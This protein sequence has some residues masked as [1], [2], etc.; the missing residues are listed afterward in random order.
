MT[1]KAWLD[2]DRYD[3]QHLVA[4]LPAGA[5]RVVQEGD[6]FFLTSTELDAC[7]GGADIEEIASRALGH[8]NGIGRLMDPRFRPVS[9]SRRYDDG[10]NAVVFVDAAVA[11]GFRVT[12]EV[13]VVDADGVAK[14]PPA[15]IAPRYLELASDPDVSDVLRI[16]GRS[17]ELS[18]ADMYKVHEIIQTRV[19]RLSD[20]N[21]GISANKEQSFTASADDPAISGEKARH[22]R[23]KGGTLKQSR[24]MSE[25]DARSFIVQVVECWLRDLVAGPQPVDRLETLGS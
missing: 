10:R 14:A 7:S 3:L 11:I 4:L 24:W 20:Q 12:A 18:F 5:I 13:V 6:G 23:R 17:A 9:L 22:A 25:S 15:P 2:G 1:L 19:G 16:L 21:W 8:L